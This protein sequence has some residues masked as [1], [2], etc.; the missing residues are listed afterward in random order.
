[1]KI[2]IADD[3]DLVRD[4]ICAFLEGEGFCTV[5]VSNY[6]EALEQVSGDEDFSAILLDYTM[7]GASGLDGLAQMLEV[8]GDTPV[9]LISGTAS[10]SVVDAAMKHGA[11]GYIPKSMPAKSMANAVRFIAA[12][13]VF[14]PFGLLNKEPEAR[15]E[16]RKLGL[17]ERELQVLA[18]L[19][20]GKSN[21]EIARDRDLQEVTIKLHVKN[22]CRKIAARNRTHAAIIAR[23]R[24]LV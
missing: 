13:E 8:V 23:D 15:S 16:G 21:K 19:C 3:H 22:L 10:Q 1:M 11:S 18:G 4:T 9:A 6:D 7:P 14:V 12:G 17:S 2:L 24:Q 20:E 5:G